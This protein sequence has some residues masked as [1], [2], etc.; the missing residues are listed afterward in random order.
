MVVIIY[1]ISYVPSSIEIQVYDLREKHSVLDIYGRQT[2]SGHSLGS[3]ELSSLGGCD[4]E[5]QPPSPMGAM[6][7]KATATGE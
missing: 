5:Q 1:I 4:L 7:S 6:T 2:R 3:I